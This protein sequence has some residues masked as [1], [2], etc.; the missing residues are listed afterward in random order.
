MSDF[1]VFGYGSLMWNPG[2]ESLEKCK[3]RVMGLH[4]SLCVHSWVHRGTQEKPGL[5]LGLDTG[6]SC[7]G[8]A[9]R[10]AGENRDPVIDY[11]RKRELTTNVYLEVLRKIV[12]QNGREVEAVLYRVDR[13]HPQY[14]HGLSVDEQTHIVRHAV[15]GSGKN[16]EY[17]INTVAC[18]RDI[19]IRDRNLE[20]I[21]DA[22]S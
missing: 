18:M 15:G 6:G 4:R 16:P 21:S 20:Q 10:V 17:V 13:S 1:W 9:Y 5:V 3:A 11:L 14:A 12:L 8:I 7:S 19:G 2:F 22:L